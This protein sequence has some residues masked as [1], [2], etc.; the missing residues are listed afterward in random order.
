MS[1]FYDIFIYPLEWLMKLVL[2][3]VLS[4]TGNPLIS[5]ICVSFV[6]VA[7]SL[8]LYHLAETWQDRERAIQKKLKP[9]ISEFK[10]VF[11]GSVLNS[12]I[13]TL[14]RQNNYHP[15]YAVRTSFG[16]LIQI[17]F[18]FAAYHLLSNYSAFEGVETIL[19]EDLGK[20]DGL[21]V[22]G[23]L[24]INIMPFVMTGINFLSAFVYGKKT[25]M[26]E[27]FQLYGIALLFLV[28]LYNSSS[29]LLFYWTF[30]NV[31]S[32]LKNIIYNRL[33]ENGV[34]VKS[35]AK[36]PKKVVE[37]EKYN[38]L[39]VTALFSF[40]MLL[41]IVS[42][43]TV[44][45]SGSPTEF[46]EP[47]F[48]FMCYLSFFSL[49]LCGL[50]Y[51]LF[52][53]TSDSVKRFFTFVTVFILFFSLINVFVFPGNYGDMSN[54]VF[55]NR[56][57]VKKTEI[58]AYII[59]YLVILAI[60][61]FLFFKNKLS[62]IYTFVSIILISLLLF[63]A[64]ESKKYVDKRNK[65]ETMIAGENSTLFSFSKNG[66]NVVV[67][68]LDRFIGGYIPQILQFMPELKSDLDGFVWYK[69]SLS[70]ASY[71]IGGVPPI[72]GGWE[73]N[74]DK[75]NG[76][77]KDVPLKQKLDESVRILPYN[78]DKAGWDVTLYANNLYRWFDKEN[79]KYL[80][81]S[82]IIEPDFKRYREL[83]LE[84][85]GG[86][87]V[88]HSDATRKLLI[89]FGIFR[90]A[91]PFLRKP[92]YDDG[93][94]LY[95]S[96]DENVETVKNKKEYIYFHEKKRRSKNITLNFYAV[97]D[98]LPQLSTVKDKK[99]NSFYYMTNDLP[100]APFTINSNF[101]YE[102]SGKFSYPKKIYRK[103]RR[104]RSALKHLYAMGASLR[105]VNNWLRWMK[106]NNVYDNTR[107]IIVSDHGRALYN[108]FFKRQKIPGAR[109][110]AHPADYNNLILVKDFGQRGTLRVEK[111]FMTC[112]DIPVIAMENIVNGINPFTG[113]AIKSPEK[114]F[115]FFVYDVQWRMER[116]KKYELVFH[117][118]YEI[119]AEKDVSSPSKWR[120]IK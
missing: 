82:E 28:V 101:E 73:Y 74:V 69:N 13:N 1:L 64:N 68:M 93:K 98:F 117:E 20:P 43:L 15:I 60:T 55:E 7:G 97:L 58:I 113:S 86:E 76:E 38:K 115:P 51:F 27:N 84:K 118:G 31:F 41:F 66:Q 10:S 36:L 54:F 30:N 112:G 104:S 71:T 111:Q 91:P 39:F 32:L 19:F 48:Y 80:G 75:I 37:E 106:E 85:R 77:R 3:M 83:W 105:L 103:F 56:I 57:L 89:A 8:P 94:W 12:Y 63:S 4:W 42:P 16:L 45:S 34:I 33:Y 59:S 61:G 23:S 90:A 5:L 18:F 67:L 92:I 44:L 78:F 102:P 29:A 116:Q 11:K 100:H 114:K 46:E 79:R 110:K 47:L 21:L 35:V 108:P 17:P 65:S 96:N 50:F 52:I 6:V 40:V 99:R 107:I 119:V 26:K 95:E 120:V 14:Y 22:L 2:E 70:P 53:L 81:D 87:P 72:M 25:T 24:S 62:I 49:I 88:L 9:K 109:K